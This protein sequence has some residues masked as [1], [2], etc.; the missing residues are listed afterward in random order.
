MSIVG[1]EDDFLR[2]FWQQQSK[3]FL[4]C[5]DDIHDLIDGNELAGLACEDEIESRIISGSGIRGDWQCRQGPFQDEDFSTLD[6][7]NWT[8]LVQG[9][10][11]WDSKIRSVLDH[12]K[13]LPSWRLEDI[14]ISY[15]PIGGGVGPHFDNYDV[16][17][18][19][20]SG[21]REWQIG[22]R[23]DDQTKLQENDQVKLLAEFDCQ[24]TSQLNPGDMIYV[25][26]GIAHWGT[27]LSDDCITLSVGFRAPSQRQLIC[28]TLENLLERFSHS[29]ADDKR[30]YRDTMLSIDAASAKINQYAHSSVYE[31][32]SEI[33]PDL[34]RAEGRRA[35]GQLVTEPRHQSEL[36]DDYEW[37]VSEVETCLVQ[38]AHLML[39]QPVHSRIAFSDNG[40]FVN[41]QAYEAEKSFSRMICEKKIDGLLSREE[42]E[43]LVRL[44]NQGDIGIQS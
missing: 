21:S 26:A 2:E 15:A 39:V 13:F 23:C 3:V 19:Q 1:N 30:F 24:S 42:L 20:S 36:D 44:L 33:S 29:D 5:F 35:F 22:Q 14:M 43:L 38:G 41:G 4:Q 6:K 18:I 32:L 37:T 28:Q 31:L 40:L 12:F 16:F 8:L 11:Q 25:P 7:E 10:E 34:V 17:L 27:A 9:V